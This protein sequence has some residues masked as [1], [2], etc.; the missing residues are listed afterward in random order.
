MNIFNGYLLLASHP[1]I[2]ELIYVT[3]HMWLNTGSH[4]RIVGKR[5]IYVESCPSNNE[6]MITPTN[7]LWLTGLTFE[8]QEVEE[9]CRMNKS[10]SQTLLSK[11]FCVA[12]CVLQQI[13][14]QP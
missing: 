12:L 6:G 7:K 1:V 5:S 8:K 13:L 10:C 3:C 11:S 9:E 2:M 14:I 4:V